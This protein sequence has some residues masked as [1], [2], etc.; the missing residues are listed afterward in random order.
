[1]VD[2]DDLVHAPGERFQA[3]F[4]EALLVAND[5]GGGQER[6][7]FD[8]LELP[9]IADDEKCLRV[10]EALAQLAA[11]DPKKAEIVKLRVFVGLKV[12]EIAALLECSEKTVQRDWTFAK[13]WLSR[14]LRE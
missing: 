3:A 6:L 7:P 13:A 8:S 1:M 4:Q 11:S 2:D 9:I 14:E 10:N 5:H 12:N